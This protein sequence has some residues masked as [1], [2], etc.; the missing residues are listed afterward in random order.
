M[1]VS[2]RC[3]ESL[4]RLWC[5]CDLACALRELICEKLQVSQASELKVV[6]TEE[7][8]NGVVSETPI[9]EQDLEARGYSA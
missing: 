3:D 5:P 2:K 6:M 7:L 1:I 8:W 4:W 9:D